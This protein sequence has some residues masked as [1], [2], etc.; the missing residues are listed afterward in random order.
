MPAGYPDRLGLADL[1]N[2][3]PRGAGGKLQL[4][5]LPRFMRL[6]VGPDVDAHALGVV[7]Q[8]ANIAPHGRAIDHQCRRWQGS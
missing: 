5:E 4:R 8:P 1:G 3:E 2:C 7:S 6:G